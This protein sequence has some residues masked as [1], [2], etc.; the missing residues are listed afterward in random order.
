MNKLRIF[1]YLLL[2]LSTTLTVW[3]QTDFRK[4][5]LI[6]N[7]SDTIPGLIDYR[8]DWKNMEECVY[9]KDAQSKAITYN[10]RQI[11]GYRFVKEGRFF[12]S[13]YI[14]TESVNDTVFL[15]YLVNG[16]TDLYFYQNSQPYAAYFIASSKGEMLELYKSSDKKVEIDGVMYLKN[17]NRYYGALNYALGDCAELRSEFETTELNHKSLIS[18]VKRYHDYKCTDQSCIVYTKNSQPLMFKISPVAGYAVSSLSFLKNE[19]F[20]RYKFK[21]GKSFVWGIDCE[22]R[23]SDMNERISVVLGAHVNYDYFYGAY[24][25]G[26]GDFTNKGVLFNDCHLNRLNLTNSFSVKRIWPHGKYRMYVVAGI[27]CKAILSEECEIVK[28]SYYKSVVST[29]RYQTET[30]KRNVIGLLGGGGVQ[31]QLFNRINGFL[32][33]NYSI[34]KTL[35]GGYGDVEKNNSIALVA[36]LSF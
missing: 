26:I 19:E 15:E 13:K 10:A 20:D 5:Y 3:G 30:T 1:I 14:K 27:Y 22:F 33:L 35:L 29:K 36:G 11:K 16:I 9:K 6:D 4:G 24:N 17:D 18:L 23:L 28:E 21:K 8:G 7:K 12:V 32:Q 2:F 31:T 34:G 25:E